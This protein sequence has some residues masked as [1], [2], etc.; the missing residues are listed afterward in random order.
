MDARFPEDVWVLVARFVASVPVGV[1]LDQHLDVFSFL[2]ALETIKAE[3][4][5]EEARASALIVGEA[6]DLMPVT[7]FYSM[8]RGAWHARSRPAL[9]GG[10]RFWRSVLSRAPHLVTAP[11]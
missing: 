4:R 1:E 7:A 5:V 6:A 3:G 10:R 8:A 11:D 2:G 9:G